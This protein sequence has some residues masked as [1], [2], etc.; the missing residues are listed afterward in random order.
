MTFKIFSNKHPFLLAFLTG[1]LAFLLA[2]LIWLPLVH[3]FFQGEMADF[4]VENGV[5][6]MGRAI[7]S[8][9]L[10][11][12]ADAGLRRRELEKMRHTNPEWAFMS[13]T[14]LVLALANMGLR[15]RAKQDQV[16]T[17]ID[18]IIDD[19]L[20]VETSRGFPFFL[21]DYGKHGGWGNQ[22]PSSLFVDGEIAL[23]LAARR[24]LRDKASYKPAM[25]KRVDKMLE[26]MKKSPVLCDESYPNECWLFCN[27][28]ALAA[29]K[30]ADH[31]DGTDH[32]DFFEAWI[33]MA[34]KKLVDQR[35]G[36][37]ISVFSLAGDP[38]PAGP[39]P[40]GSS[41]WMA[42]HMLQAVDGG[43]AED[44]YRKAR[45]HFG[46]SFLGFGYSREWP[47]GMTGHMDIDS[48]PVVP[49]FGASASASGLAILAAAAFDDDGYLQALFTSL[50]FAGFPEEVDG[51]LRYLAGNPVGD[52]VLLYALMEGPLWQLIR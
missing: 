46:D 26:R 45:A 14:Y 33:A 5:P 29:M 21:M 10:A 48:G 42:C 13:R 25:R 2:A 24:C 31:L 16:C 1:A 37:L 30:M 27:T 32:S 52:A 50:A 40:E 28:V 19:T 15:E 7:A 41:L 23:M 12:W 8:A 49:L 38:L 36:M 47:K 20:A 39:G 35:T 17:I 18:A 4:K 34:G 3:L 43:F 51:K 44:Q 6:P 22:P 11:I 9:H